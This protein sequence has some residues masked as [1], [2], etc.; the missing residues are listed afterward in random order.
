[1]N[2][3]CLLL[4]E[5]VLHYHFYG[6]HLNERD[7]KKNVQKNVFGEGQAMSILDA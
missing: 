1:M 4:T 6:F 2:E 5:D 7:E 3:V